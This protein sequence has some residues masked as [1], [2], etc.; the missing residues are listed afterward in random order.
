MLRNNLKHNYLL[1]NK[2]VLSPDRTATEEEKKNMEDNR[3]QRIR[4]AF[5]LGVSDG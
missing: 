1:E 3:R 2:V 5:I 4:M